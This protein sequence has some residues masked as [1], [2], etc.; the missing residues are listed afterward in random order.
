MCSKPLAVHLVFFEETQIDFPLIS[1]G[2]KTAK[3]PSYK[4]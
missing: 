1:E 2:P 4:D 3:D